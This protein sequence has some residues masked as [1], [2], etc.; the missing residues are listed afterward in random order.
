V[1]LIWL[2]RH[3]IAGI[4]PGRRLVVRGRVAEHDARRVIFNPYYE[5]QPTSGQ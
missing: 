5:I 2:G 4:E 1:T 3:R